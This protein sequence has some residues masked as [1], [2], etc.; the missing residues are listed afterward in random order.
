MF[1]AEP[2]DLCG[3]DCKFHEDLSSRGSGPWSPAGSNFNT[4]KTW[5][6]G[7]SMQTDSREQS[8]KCVDLNLF[9]Y[10]FFR[11]L[12]TNCM[13][14]LLLLLRFLFIYLFHSM[15]GYTLKFCLSIAE[16]LI[17]ITILLQL[18][19]A[20]PSIVI[21]KKLHI[22]LCVSKVKDLHGKG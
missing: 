19:Q 21:R 18:H 5:I 2:S 22:C 12:L 7:S 13:G 11:L 15:V 4:S 20:L 9:P 17:N 10:S 14:T 16:L 8:Y 1:S 3:P 6:P